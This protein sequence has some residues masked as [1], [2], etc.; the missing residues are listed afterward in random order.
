MSA[1]NQGADGSFNASVQPD[2]GLDQSADAP[3][4]GELSEK[5]KPWDKH[6][7]NADRI[8]A[9]YWAS[10][11]FEQYA[12]RVAD[13]SQ[14]L[15]FKL[16]AGNGGLMSLKLAGARFC[17]VRHCPVCQ[18]RRSLR[19][20]AKAHKVLPQVIEKYPKYRWLFLTLTV[21]NVPIT[22]LR[23]TLQ[24]MNK[25]YQRMVQRKMWPAEGWL[26]STEVTRGRHGSAHP[27]FHSL[28]LVRPSFFSHNY[29]RQDQ[30][31]DLWCSC[32]RLDYTP[33]VD[34]R[35]VKQGKQPMQLIPE[36]LKYC[37]KESDLVVDR[38]WF[39]ELTRQMFK[40]RCISTG[41]VL[42]QYLKALEQ[43]PE[44]LIG[45]SDDPD[46]VDEGS[47][48]FGWRQKHKKYRLVDY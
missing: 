27:H 32:A 39:L 33:I 26:R 48:Y 21:K 42:K 10:A 24:H 35:A 16:A 14:L 4:L 9:H 30:W 43:E 22:E 45:E 36:L 25:S 5:D 20:K 46:E 23:E 37:V 38:E 7:S 28:L 41:G 44:D 1:A 6:R 47:L 12:Q 11:E 18:W 3:S 2:S 31:A 13:C 40:L 15:E 19:W 8:Q 29:I 17:R 34:A